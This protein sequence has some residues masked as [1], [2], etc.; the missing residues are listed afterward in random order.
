MPPKKDLDE[1]VI[2]SED[3]LK[4]LCTLCNK[5]SDSSGWI[6]C[7]SLVTHLASTV[8]AKSV[9]LQQADKQSHRICTKNIQKP[10]S[11][12]RASTS[13]AETDMWASYRRDGAEFN[14]GVDHAVDALAEEAKFNKGLEDYGIW[15]AEALGHEL[16]GDLDDEDLWTAMLADEDELVIDELLGNLELHD[17]A[18]A[19]L[20]KTEWYPYDSKVMF[21]LDTLDNLPRLFPSG[22]FESQACTMFKVFRLLLQRSFVIQNV[23]C[24]V[25]GEQKDWNNTL[26]R[27]HIHVYPEIPEDGIISEIWH[28]EKWCKHM[29]LT[30]LSPMCDDGASQH[31][32]VNE[33]AMLSAPVLLIPRRVVTSFVIPIRW[34]M[35]RG[36]VHADAFLVYLNP[37]NTIHN[38]HPSR[39]PNP[40]RVIAGGDP[41]YTSFVNHFSDDV[42]GNCSK[43]WNKHRNGYMTHWNLPRK[44][45]QQEFHVHF[46]LTS[47]HVTVAEQF[48]AFKEAIEKTHTNPLKPGEAQDK[49]MILHLIKTQLRLAYQ[50]IA[51]LVKTAQTDS[52]INDTF[53]QYWIEDILTQFKAMNKAGTNHTQEDITAELLKWVNDNHDKIFSPFLNLKGLD[54]T[55]DTPVEIL[56]TI[57]L[58]I[59]KYI[60]HYSHTQWTDSKKQTY[61]HHLQATNTTGLS[62]Q[63]IRVPYIMQY[64]NSLIGHQLKTLMQANVFHVYDLVDRDHFAVWKAVRELRALLWHPEIKDIEEYCADLRVSVTNVLD[65]F[66]LIDPSKMVMKIK[67]H[68]LTH[69]PDDT[70]AFGPL[71]GMA[72]EIYEA[73]NG[74]FR[75]A[76]VLSNHISPSWDIAL[77]LA[78]QEGLKHGA[79]DSNDN[80]AEWKC[81]G[82]RVRTFLE[83]QPSLQKLL[84]WTPPVTWVPG[85]NCEAQTV[86][87]VV[88]LQD[89]LAAKAVNFSVY[90][91]DSNWMKCIQTTAISDETVAGRIT[92]ILADWTIPERPKTTGIVVLDQFQINGTRHAKFGMPV[93]TQR[94]EEQLSVIVATK[95]DCCTAKCTATGIHPIVQECVQT[96]ASES[97]IEH[98]PLQQFI[99]NT[100]AL[101]NAH[102][103][104]RT[105]PWQLTKPIA[106]PTEAQWLQFHKESAAAFQKARITKQ[107][108][109]KGATAWKKLEKEKLKADQP[110][111]LPEVE[112]EERTQKRN[113]KVVK[114]K[115]AATSSPSSGDDEDIDTGVTGSRK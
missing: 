28:A 13:T 109:R 25:N 69:L 79:T 20:A 59:I 23:F 95:H 43:S 80:E 12:P 9:A 42:S 113:R 49:A 88:K 72:T 61:V 56:H 32:Y 98:W 17:Q 36:K 65:G 54:P 85:R 108:E 35:Y 90:P 112:Q 5:I 70:H 94:H 4:V 84:G 75:Y 27:Q 31:F 10:V 1:F 19:S 50:G 93:L 40:D 51:G 105:L 37:Q 67:L 57:L 26:V 76:S 74:V 106:L 14:A 78:G 24:G 101:H 3:G 30:L 38:G 102:L 18:T 86:R 63:A 96:I 111:P 103:L 115:R 89:T 2:S 82:S 99:V 46:V 92:E 15:N 110:E 114:K 29:D 39:M 107:Q 77:Q 34:V 81:A 71:I 83:S 21:L 47:Q 73:F 45:L 41:L 55:K 58:S 97:F 48:A 33:L 6:L 91:K 64:A 62:I 104:R 66:A 44:L 11:V 53:T 87:A 22:S 52:G 8:H 60:W 68:L 7:W 16:G 100:T